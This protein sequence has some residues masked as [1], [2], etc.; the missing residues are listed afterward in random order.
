V[1]NDRVTRSGGAFGGDILV[2][3]DTTARHGPGESGVVG[4]RECKEGEREGGHFVAQCAVVVVFCSS[5]SPLGVFRFRLKEENNLQALIHKVTS[6]E[7]SD[8]TRLAC[9]A[10]SLSQRSRTRPQEGRNISAHLGA[11]KVNKSREH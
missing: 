8:V 6:Q 4:E 2:S 5:A 11:H 7:Y 3:W 9:Y 1:A 10:A